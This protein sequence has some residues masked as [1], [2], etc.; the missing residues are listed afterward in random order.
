MTKP[1]ATQV[2]PYAR[3]AS[4]NA[5][6]HFREQGALYLKNQVTHQEAFQLVA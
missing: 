3:T 6:H 1:T 5:T 4:A 2:Q